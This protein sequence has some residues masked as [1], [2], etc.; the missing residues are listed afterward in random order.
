MR[1]DCSSQKAGAVGLA[2][3][4]RKQTLASASDGTST[5]V[6][7]AAVGTLDNASH[8]GSNKRQDNGSLHLCNI[9]RVLLIGTSG[10][11]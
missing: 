4:N 6:G 5:V 1:S 8:G 7:I 11:T 10:E 9:I 2:R 3:G